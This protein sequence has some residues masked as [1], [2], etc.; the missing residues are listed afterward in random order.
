MKVWVTD[1]CLST[2]IQEFETESVTYPCDGYDFAY[3]K[4]NRVTDII[5]PK[6]HIHEIYAL[7]LQKA[8]KMKEHELKRLKDEFNHVS[9]IEF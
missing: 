8:Y 5:I 6:S 1:T 7:A 3:I 2:G 4:L 9:L